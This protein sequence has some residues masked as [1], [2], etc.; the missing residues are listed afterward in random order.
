MIT[1]KGYV[2]GFPYPPVGVAI[3]W[4]ADM[5]NEKG[6]LENFIRYFEQVMG[7]GSDDTW[8]QKCKSG[9]KHKILYVYIIINNYVAYRLNYIEFATGPTHINNGDGISFSRRTSIS[10]SRL[11]MAGPFVKAPVEIYCRGF[12]GFRYTDLL[13]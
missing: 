9:P 10:W 3:T 1:T 6:G 4:S 2:K 11:V 7:E 13:F 12:Q 5:I 8:L